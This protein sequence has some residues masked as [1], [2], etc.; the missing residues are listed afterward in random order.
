LAG[1]EV[2]TN[3][4]FSGGHRGQQQSAADHVAQLA[5][6]LFPLS[7]FAH[8]PRQFPAAQFGMISQQTPEEINLL[9]GNAPAP[10]A[11]RDAHGS[12]VTERVSERKYIK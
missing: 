6:G 12:S 3:G 4:R 5:V 7:R 11:P 2:A 1:F 8:L 10:I 9:A